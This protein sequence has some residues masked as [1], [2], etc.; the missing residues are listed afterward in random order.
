[1]FLIDLYYTRFVEIENR[2]IEIETEALLDSTIPLPFFF[3]C[4]TGSLEGQTFKKTGK[5][6]SLSE[7]NLVDC[8]RN[9]GNSGCNGG[10]MEYAFNYIRSNRA[11]TLK[12]AT[13]TWPL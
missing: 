6:V 9:Y 10:S 11:S 12:R 3:S 2:N 7:Q 5:L 13:P 8:S 4:Q 1:M